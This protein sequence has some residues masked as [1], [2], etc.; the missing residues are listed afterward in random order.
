M[1]KIIRTSKS[2]CYMLLLPFLILEGCEQSNGSENYAG[3]YN[4]EEETIITGS[5]VPTGDFQYVNHV[6]IQYSSKGDKVDIPV[7]N[8]EFKGQLPDSLPE[9]SATLIFKP[10]PEK[11]SREEAFLFGIRNLRTFYIDNNEIHIS[12]DGALENSVVQGGDQNQHLD[13]YY[14]LTYSLQAAVDTLR[15]D[16]S[17]AGKQIYKETKAELKKKKQEFIASNPSSWRSLEL[18][19]DLVQTYLSY[20]W[21]NDPEDTGLLLYKELYDGLIPALKKEREYIG[22]QLEKSRA[23]EFIPFI[24]EMANGETFDVNSLK[25]KV[26]LI[27]FWGSWCSW[28]R[29]GH[30]HMKELYAKYKDQGF[31]I[32]GIGYEYEGDRENQWKLFKGAIAKDGIS[33]PQVLNDP[34]KDDL[35][36]KYMITSYPTK[37]LVDREG[38]VLLRT[39]SDAERRIDAKLAQLFDSANQ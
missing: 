10:D 21:K 39:G 31:E 14:K 9:R 15:Y 17:P 24:G 34:S 13:E 16:K 37:I 4:A 6:E 19:D 23:R 8:N 1:N 11:L 29:K 2:A 18:L 25:G 5:I 12:I 36:K 38:K 3:K 28:C 22:I 35:V 30:P 33:W 20:E 32:I 7:V 27:D 26:F